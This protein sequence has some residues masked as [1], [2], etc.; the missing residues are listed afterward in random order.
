MGFTNVA[1]ESRS[2]EQLARGLTTGPGPMPVGQAGAAWVRVA[3]EWAS[4]SKEYDKVVDQIKTSFASRGADAVARKLDE[5]GQWLRSAS[6]CAADNG[7]RA[8]QAAVAYSA[9]VLAMPSVSEA[10]ETRT[11]HDVMASLAAYNGAVLNGQFAEFDQALAAHQAN[12]SAVMYQYEEA[13]SGLAAPWQ[14]PPVPH[15]SRGDVHESDRHAKSDDD[16]VGSVHP[17]GGGGAAVPPP[18]P[19]APFRANAVKSSANPKESVK[20]EATSGASGMAGM[21]G[22][23]GPMAALARG[24]GTREHQSSLAVTLDG[25]GEPG[26]GIAPGD[27]SWLPATQHSDS[28][29][30]VSHVSWGANTAVFDEL[31][32]PAEPEPPQ[33]ADAAQPTLEQ[34]SNRWVSPPV[35]GADERS[36]P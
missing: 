22:G 34:V 18:P 20:I 27:P 31:A 24:A 15:V 16:G 14:Q 6:L 21:G 25:G 7:R 19:L 29:V 23:Y 11:A 36:T 33:Y 30:V 26:A 35:I 13:C 10:I 3:D 2:A 17:G 8:E 9:A 5:F 1:W 4:I 32:A 28:P 12:A